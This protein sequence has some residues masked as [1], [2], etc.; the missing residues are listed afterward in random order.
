L[1]GIRLTGAWSVEFEADR[2]FSTFE[3]NDPPSRWVSFA[4]PG[5]PSQEIERLGVH[6]RFTRIHTARD[7]YSVHGVWKT[8]E[9]GR[10]NAAVY[11]GVSFRNFDNRVIRTIT[12]VPDDPAIPLDHPDVRDGDETRT[13]TGG[14]L[15]GGVMV[16]VTLTGS[17]TVAPEFRFT[18]GKITDES[19][20]KIFAA[21]VRFMWGL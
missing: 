15:T 21:A 5:S 4:P 13:I 20:Y 1:I 6:A 3:R 12:R 2:G 9:P 14:G 19:T 16:P 10:V 18:L 8:R 17:V 7:G 11:G